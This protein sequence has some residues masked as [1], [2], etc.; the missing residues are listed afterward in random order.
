MA[1]D[2]EALADRRAGPKGGGAFE[3][4]GGNGQ[5]GRRPIGFKDISFCFELWHTADA[6][7]G[8]VKQS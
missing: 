6:E 8:A 2:L 4:I 7:A 1:E 3:G 5:G